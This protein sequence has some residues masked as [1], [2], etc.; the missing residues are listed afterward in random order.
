MR[1]TCEIRIE[2]ITLYKKGLTKET[3]WSRGGESHLLK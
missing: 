3:V 1:N 2:G